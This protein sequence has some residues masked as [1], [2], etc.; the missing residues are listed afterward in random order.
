[1]DIDTYLK[2]A[3]I[4][5]VLD[6][7][8]DLG[9]ELKLSDEFNK[10]VIN[11]F[12]RYLYS[13]EEDADER[14]DIIAHALGAIR[15]LTDIMVKSCFEDVECIINHKNRI[16]ERTFKLSHINHDEVDQSIN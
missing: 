16:L 12:K 10:A 15:N 4:A 9:T 13:I 6:E 2:N 8:I 14:S 3:L 7:I 11:R 5:S 1:M